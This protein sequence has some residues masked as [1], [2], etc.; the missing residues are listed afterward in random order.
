MRLF[1]HR[2]NHRLICPLKT[3]LVNQIKLT[4]VVETQSD[5]SQIEQQTKTKMIIS[6]CS[7]S[8]IEKVRSFR[9]QSVNATVLLCDRF[10]SEYFANGR[11]AQGRIGAG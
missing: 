3:H 11:R 1:F 5:G 10:E 8:L 9:L 2:R 4:F 6:S 7:T